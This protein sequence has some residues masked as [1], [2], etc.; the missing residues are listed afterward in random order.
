MAQLN[1]GGVKVRGK[2]NNLHQKLNRN[3]YR[4]RPKAHGGRPR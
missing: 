4:S 2:F 3:R 1:K